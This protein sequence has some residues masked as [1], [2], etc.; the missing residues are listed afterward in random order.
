MK[1]NYDYDKL[2]PYMVERD[3]WVCYD[4]TDDDRKIPYIPGSDKKARSNDPTTFRTY[5]E[6]FDDVASGARDH[7]GYMLTKDDNL[8]FFDLDHT[9]DPAEKA[10]NKLIFQT[11]NSY[12]ERSVS[13]KGAHILAFGKL[14]GRGLHTSHLG[15]YDQSRGILVTGDIIQ[16]RNKIRRANKVALR[17]LQTKVR[18]SDGR[19]YDF[20]LEETEWDAAPWAVLLLASK[21]YGDKFHA[22]LDGRW[23][24]LG[25]PSQ[26]EADHALTNMFCDIS[27][28]NPLVR[29]LF[30]ESGLYRE[31]KSR[32]DETTGEYSVKGY[33][34]YSIKQNRA[35]ADQR[36]YVKERV[37]QDIKRQVEEKIAATPTPTKKTKKT[38]S[39]HKLITD[40]EINAACDD[41]VESVDGKE[42]N[43]PTDLIKQVP[44]IVHRGLALYFYKNSYRPNQEVAILC[45]HVW[46]TMVSQRAYFTPTGSG[47]NLNFWL[48]A[49]TG[50]GKDVFTKCINLV[51]GELMQ[52]QPKLGDN[53]VGKFASGE[54]V[55][56]VISTQPRFM[57]RVSEAGAFWRKLLS[58]HRPPHIDVLVESV[59]NLFMSTSPGAYWQ[60]RKKAKKDEDLRDSIFRP[61]GSFYGESTPEDLLGDLDINSISTGLLQRQ[62][63]YNIS[64]ADYVPA[65]KRS[66]P[67]SSK[68]KARLSDMIAVADNLDLMEETITVKNSNRAAM[69]L[70]Q[71]SESHSEYAFRKEK[72]SLRAN[73]M[74]R[75]GIK[76][77]RMAS[78]MAVGDDPHD[79]IIREKHARYAID[80]IQ[81][82]DEFI[83][84]KFQ[85]G[86]IGKGQLKQEVDMMKI[87]EKV[88]SAP[89]NNRRRSYRMNELCA[90][91]ASVIPYSF[92]KNKAKSRASFAG[93]KLGAITAI[94]KCIDSLCRAGTL[95]RLTRVECE[96]EYE[97][98]AGL[99]RF[100]AL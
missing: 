76:A 62:I 100:T 97:T 8:T 89:E 47:N 30:A 63:F 73:L 39:K 2:P 3:Q 22:L 38:K 58:P 60:S 7:L 81:Q 61:A 78:L 69:M 5:Q 95:V 35:K 9:D 45:A 98:T 64:Q 90:A 70:D 13:G 91:D 48:I 20:D 24:G 41:R 77:Y 65:N 79:P 17:S 56:T 59:L 83:L 99:L 93:D 32:R 96:T 6:A 55:E 37:K 94:D 88:V 31:H 92:I 50:W 40:S 23:E 51:V 82:C 84:E 28:S 4:I 12:S 15:L 21:I 19:G 72:S 27:D 52:D 25:Y 16:G 57:S 71:Y 42:F 87:I 67:M 11:F 54:A 68:L 49:Q 85:S 33:L 1:V 26:S 80:F 36:E 10:A 44:S 29:Y 43:Y 34:D 53:H 74:N 66:Y 75:S 86:D 14:E 18:T 46:V